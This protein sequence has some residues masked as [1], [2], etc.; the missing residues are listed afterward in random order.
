MILC[1][2]EALIDMLPMST[3][4]GIDGYVPHA[5][6][7][8]FNTAIT[9]GRLGV[10]AGMLAGLS[11]DIFGQQ[12]RKALMGSHVDISF[13]VSTN[14][15]TTLA[16][17]QLTNGHATY[18]F[19][20]ENSAGRMLLPDDLPTLPSEVSALYFSGI[21]LASEPGAEAYASLCKKEAANRVVMVD[22][23]IRPS[24]ISDE[25]AFRVRM[26]RM[27]AE[28][29]I[30]KVSDEDLN[31]MVVGPASFREKVGVILDKGPKML[32]ITRGG[33]G[34]FAYTSCGE[35]VSVP[36]VKVAVRDTVGA[37]DTFNGGFLAKLAEMG[38]L[39]KDRLSE[40]S[41]EE[42]SEALS[43]GAKV[44]SINVSREGANPP[45]ANEL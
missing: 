20:D 42:I 10:R 11:S 8:V 21:S 16:F 7:A 26:D 22:P 28:A 19:Y 25:T 1:C 45:W 12:L 23:N 5:G 34:A 4:D 15:P 14:R 3:S 29:D 18:S 35:E 9:L 24:F 31:W 36:S 32:V 39:S 27:L 43:L 30:V 40:I 17:V 37:G 2:G 33:E 41:R 44:A 38:L 6:G 13:A